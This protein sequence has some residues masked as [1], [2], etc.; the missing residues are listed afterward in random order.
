MQVPGILSR[1]LSLLEGEKK[2]TDDIEDASDHILQDCAT[3]LIEELGRKYGNEKPF[4]YCA[5]DEKENNVKSI[6]LLKNELYIEHVTGLA[7]DQ[8]Q[9]RQEAKINLE[10][11]VGLPSP[12]QVTPYGD[13]GVTPHSEQ[14]PYKHTDSDILRSDIFTDAQSND[15]S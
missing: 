14:C 2:A 8:Y 6:I 3:A 15:N 1:Y 13:R 7:D 12:I 10:A 9:S 4:F 11:I 5:E